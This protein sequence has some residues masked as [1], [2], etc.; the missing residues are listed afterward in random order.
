VVR[1]V[2]ESAVSSG[3]DASWS[4]VPRELVLALIHGLSPFS[5]LGLL[6][7]LALA[8]IVTAVSVWVRHVQKMERAVSAGEEAAR[9]RIRE[10]GLGAVGALEDATRRWLDERQELARILDEPSTSQ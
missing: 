9:N 8:Y 5:I 2:L 3:D 6:L 4:Q 7:A 10:T 1:S